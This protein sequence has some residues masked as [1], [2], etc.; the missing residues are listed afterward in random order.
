[1]RTTY[2]LTLLFLLAGYTSFGYRYRALLPAVDSSGYYK[3]RLTPEINA[4]LKSDFS[5]LRLADSESHEI[6][7]LLNEDQPAQAP[8]RFKPYPI[9]SK[10]YLKDS[11]TQLILSNASGDKINNISLQIGNAEVQKTMSLSG[12]YD[13]QQWF[14]VKESALLSSLNNANEVSEIRLINFPLSNYAF[15]KIEISDKHSPPLNILNAGAYESVTTQGSFSLLKS[16]WTVHDSLQKKTSWFHLKLD[17]AHALDFLELDVSFPEFFVRNASVYQ[18]DPIHPGRKKLVQSAVFTSKSAIRLDFYGLRL[19]ELW[20][21]ISNDDNPPLKIT[22][23]RACQVSHF[24]LARLEKNKSY[25]LQFADSLLPAPRYDLKYFQTAI[26]ATLN[27]LLPGMPQEVMQAEKQA[28]TSY[29][30]FADKRF[31]WTALGI[32][33]LILAV[34]TFR[35]MKEIK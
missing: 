3:I 5:D 1:M 22:E 14:V 34:A 30:L 26:P 33:V 27:T 21:E 28:D 29:S 17:E 7:Y 25:E 16:S 2:L 15:Y 9:V 35:M 12:S 31:L 4:K 13:R 32:V 24:C 8:A 10:N 19:Q 11:L 20:I 6:P 23:A 18:A